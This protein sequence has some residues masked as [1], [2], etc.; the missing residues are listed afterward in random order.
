ME[1]VTEFKK[2][3]NNKSIYDV[4]I[5]FHC[6]AYQSIIQSIIQYASIHF[7]VCAQHFPTRMH[8]IYVM[9]GTSFKEFWT[10]KRW[11]IRSMLNSD[12]PYPHR[13]GVK[14][15]RIF[16]PLGRS[17]LGGFSFQKHSLINF[18]SPSF[19]KMTSVE[20]NI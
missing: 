6:F 13:R 20:V 10:V 4:L 1:Q 15:K 9:L 12:V 17:V 16:V 8:L 18:R 5:Y 2:K 11:I 3:I 14:V 7:L 19:F